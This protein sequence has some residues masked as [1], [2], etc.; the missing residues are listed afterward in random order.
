MNTQ[1]S[2]I[3]SINFFALAL[4]AGFLFLLYFGFEYSGSDESALWAAMVYL[5]MA[6][7]LRY[8]VPIDHRKGLR[9]FKQG[10]YTEA[11]MH[12]EKS[13]EFFS[14]Y[15]WID[16]FRV[17]TIFSAS[18]LSYREMAVMYKG[19]CLELLGRGAEME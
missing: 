4:Q 5:V 19:I 2:Y 12:F 11:L 9:E 7:G 8:F 6:Y 13:L 15:P 3:H 10:N 18:K 1:Q 14:K 17:F 16:Y